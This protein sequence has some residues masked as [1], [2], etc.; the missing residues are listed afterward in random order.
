MYLSEKDVLVGIVVSGCIFY[1]IVGMEYVCLVGVIVVL[2]VCNLGCLM[3]VYVDIV[4][5]FVVGVEVVMG[6]LCMK[7]GIV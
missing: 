7:V 1:V 2:L 6:L 5:I 3:E 4:I